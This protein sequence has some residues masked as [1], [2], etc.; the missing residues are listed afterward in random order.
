MAPSDKTKLKN[1]QAENRQ[2]Q[3]RLAMLQAQLRQ[4]QQ[5]A[6]PPPPVGNNNGGRILRSARLPT[7][8]NGN[9]APA[10]AAVANNNP[11]PP[12]NGAPA[13]ANGAPAVAAM[14]AAPAFAGLN[15]PA[16]DDATLQAA[17][18]SGAL[19]GPDQSLLALMEADSASKSQNKA[20]NLWKG[21]IRTAIKEKCFKI[22]KFNSGP[23]SEKSFARQVLICIGAAGFDPKKPEDKA[24]VDKWLDTYAPTCTNLL[25]EHRSYVLGRIKDECKEYWTNHNK[26]MPSMDLIEKCLKREIGILPPPANAGDAPD[27][28]DVAIA[29]EE[30]ELF[31]WW[32]DELLPKATGNSGDWAVE[33]RHYHPISTAAP[34]NNPTNLYMPVSTEAFAA[35]AIENNHVKW[36]AMF[37][38]Y[39]DYP[40]KKQVFLLKDGGGNTITTDTVSP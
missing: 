16:M 35:L 1:S 10:A 32:W 40:K 7:N 23:T 30:Q 29:E 18:L 38:A 8:D 6:P 15:L 3:Q 26:T 31:D 34:P 22:R 12:T 5:Q 19:P 11:Q 14:A 28:A 36:P 21:H 9:G 4:H 37:Q 20:N 25:N 17:L 27:P 33:K 2:L 39:L 24:N 13:V